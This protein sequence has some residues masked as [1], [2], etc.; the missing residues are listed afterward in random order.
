VFYMSQRVALVDWDGTIRKDFTI[1]S[2]ARFLV[3]AGIASRQIIADLENL[4]ALF[5][6]GRISHDN[7]AKRSALIYA[8][9]LK[10]IAQEE[11]NRYSTLFLKTDRKH[12]IN[13]SLQLLSYLSQN[14]VDIVIISG[15]PSDVLVKYKDVLP[16]NRIYGLELE[17]KDGFYTGRAKTNPGTSSTKK[18]II[19]ML[20][21]PQGQNRVVLAMGNS[22]SDVPLF[23]AAPVRVVVNNPALRISKKVFH[24]LPRLSSNR[25]IRQIEKEVFTNGEDN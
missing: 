1:R 9:C 13:T 19:K 23:R 22:S 6:E 24:L 15:A 4:F 3:N 7:L 12:L 18:R 16:L 8:A 10:N 25:L 2:W 5:S 17:M 14:G 21:E 11:I 20:L